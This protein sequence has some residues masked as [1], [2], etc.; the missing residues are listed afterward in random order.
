MGLMDILQQ[1]AN[2]AGSNPDVAHQHFDEVARAAP[3]DIVGNGVADA[4][5]ADSTPP[6]G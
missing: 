5:R 1:Y 3:P 6:F 2:P 4:F